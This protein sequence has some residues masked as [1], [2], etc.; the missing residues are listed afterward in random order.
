MKNNFFNCLEFKKAEKFIETNPVLAKKVFE[1]YVEKYPEDYNALYM[2]AYVLIILKDLKGA[3]M[4]AEEAKR[5]YYGDT[6]FFRTNKKNEW[7]DYNSKLINIRILARE[8]RY[9]ELKD[10]YSEIKYTHTFERLDIIEDVCNI[11]LGLD[12]DISKKPYFL[13]QIKSYSED[14]FYYHVLRH[15]ADY[16]KDL[17]TP[18]SSFFSPYFNL[19]EVIKELKQIIPNEKGLG[20]GFFEDSYVFRYDNCGR[21][22]H[23]LQD[24]FKVVTLSDSD[25]LLTMYPSDKLKDMPNIDLNYLNKSR[26]KKIIVLSP[27]DKFNKKYKLSSE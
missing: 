23:K 26:E 3:K 11:K 27:I 2:F 5:L 15:T 17:T 16:N 12:I 18:K 14:D 6:H 7:V 22:N 21:T 1:E 25:N 19:E 10:F 4:V 9:S 13:K 24:Y 8:K 20:Y